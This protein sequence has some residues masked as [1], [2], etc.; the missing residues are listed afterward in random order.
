[1]AKSSAPPRFPGLG[2]VPSTP[3]TVNWVEPMRTCLPIGSTFGKERLPR[4]VAEEDDLPAMLGFRREKTRPASTFAK[5][6]ADQF[7]VAPMMPTRLV[8]S[9]L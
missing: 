6:T 4:A 1:M 7:S 8:F 2:R 9:L 5:L 3:M